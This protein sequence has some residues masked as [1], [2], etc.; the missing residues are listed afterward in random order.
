MKKQHCGK[1]ISLLFYKPEENFVFL[2]SEKTKWEEE[3]TSSCE[4][5]NLNLSQ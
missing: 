3:N 4:D 5:C 1:K 2:S